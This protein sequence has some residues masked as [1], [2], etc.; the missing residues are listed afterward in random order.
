[1]LG[2]KNGFPMRKKDET[3]AQNGFKREEERQTKRANGAKKKKKRVTGKTTKK[4]KTIAF[5]TTVSFNAE[6]KCLALLTE[7]GK[8]TNGF[9]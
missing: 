1:M 3:K 5:E 6:E 7:A 9:I 2:L 4:K 8:C